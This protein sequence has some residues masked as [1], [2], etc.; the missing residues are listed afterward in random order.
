MFPTSCVLF[1]SSRTAPSNSW[2]TPSV[3]MNELT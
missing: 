3:A 1:E 2:L